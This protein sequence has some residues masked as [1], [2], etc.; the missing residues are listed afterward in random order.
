MFLGLDLSLHL[1]KLQ[2]SNDKVGLAQQV[3]SDIVYILY[4]YSI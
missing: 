2:I 4:K 1:K 3:K